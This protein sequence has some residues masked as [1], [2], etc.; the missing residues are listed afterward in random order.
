M[1]LYLKIAVVLLTATAACSDKSETTTED[2]LKS[3]TWAGTFRSKDIPVDQAFSI[4]FWSN[5]DF[6]WYDITQTRITGTWRTSGTEVLLTFPG[7]ETLVA[8]VVDDHW[9]LLTPSSNNNYS[10]Q[11]VYKTTIPTKA[12]LA[13]TTWVGNTTNPDALSLKLA[14]GTGNDVTLDDTIEKT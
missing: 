11:S 6:D 5:N 3:T 12:R 13:S 4:V 14:F 8:T 9:T 2:Q 10:L 7:E 1:K